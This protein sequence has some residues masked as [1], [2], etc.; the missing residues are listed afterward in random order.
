MRQLT[1][2]GVNSWSPCWSSDGNKIIFVAESDDRS[3]IFMMNADGTEKISLT[4]S[5]GSD[6]SPDYFDS[7]LAHLT[8]IPPT[9]TKIPPTVG[10]L[11]IIRLSKSSMSN[12]IQLEVI[13]G[14]YKLVSATE[15]WED[16]SISVQEDWMTFPAGLAIQVGEGGVS[17]KGKRYSSGTM[18]VVDGQG[19]LVE[20][21][22]EVNPGLT[23]PS[24]DIL[25]CNPVSECPESAVI[26]NF[27]DEV[28][29]MG[30]NTENP[31]SVPMD[32]V[33][34]S[35]N[36]TLEQELLEQNLKHIEI[37]FTVDDV[38]FIDQFKPRTYTVQDQTD[39][40]K[41]N[42]CHSV[43]GVVSGW[44]VDHTYRIVFGIK[45]EEAIFDGRDIYEQGECTLTYLI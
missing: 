3:K 24:L 19:N 18:L 26:R 23:L 11:V 6:Y 4:T 43:N 45:Y 28:E 8:P 35:L 37:A 16:S 1:E 17:L 2:D 29:E 27:P 22:S 34:F 42:Y 7:S 40:T 10:P 32:E 44:Q 41:L 30:C 5:D 13:K 31:V 9:T 12:P 21:A 25:G 15:L 39:S 38:S 33:G 20:T 36:G 14:K